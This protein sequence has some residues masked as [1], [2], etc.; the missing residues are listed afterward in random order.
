MPIYDFENTKT[1]EQFT[2]NISNQEREE[3][4]KASPD[5]IQVLS[6]LNVG[7]PINLHVTKP[8]TDF[9]KYV[10]GKVKEKNPGGVALERRYTIPKEI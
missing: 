8:P 10:L 2:L 4:L 6:R 7:D 3:F 5:I 1:G 9:Q